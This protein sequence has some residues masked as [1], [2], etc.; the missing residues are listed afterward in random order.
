MGVV[1]DYVRYYRE[2]DWPSLTQVFAEGD[3]ERM[4]PYC[5]VIADRDE[6]VAFL[7]RV[8]PTM[9]EGY[10][11]RLDRA[12]YNE[13]E[14]VAFA[15]MTEHYQVD[16]TFKDVPELILFDLTDDDRH[17]RRM[18]L[19]LQ[20]PGGVAPVGGKAAMGEPVDA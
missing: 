13:A 4:G 2:H 9:N 14:H 11:L 17:I 18:R 3:F 12:V 8:A 15:Q 16:G 20:Q 19:Y 1:E 7:A 6:Y 10:E 5:D